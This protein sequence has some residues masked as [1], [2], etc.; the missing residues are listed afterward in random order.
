MINP[1][2][3][4]NI[5]IEMTLQR[6]LL[7]V[8]VLTLIYFAAQTTGGDHG[9]RQF[10]LWAFAASAI[11]W[12]ARLANDSVLEEIRDHTWE[13]QRMSS[14][15]A[16][17]MAWGKLFGATIYAW[18]IAGL[19]LLFY[20][21]GYPTAFSFDQDVKT[22]ILVV[23][24]GVFVHTVAIMSSLEVSR[25]DGKR[26][27]G[28][29]WLFIVVA[30]LSVVS[31]VVGQR[32][33]NTE[34]YG[35]VVWYN[36]EANRLDFLVWSAVVF[37]AWGLLGCYRALRAELLYRTTPLAWLAFL[38]F[39][40][41]YYNGFT[42]AASNAI[43]AWSRQRIA[44]NGF[45]ATIFCSYLIAISSAWLMVLTEN[46]D[47]SRFRKA[48]LRFADSQRRSE[49][50]YLVPKW[51][52]SAAL[53]VILFTSIVVLRSTLGRME[54]DF[55]YSTTLFAAALLLLF[56]RDTL[57][58]LWCHCTTGFKRR[59]NTTAIIYFFILYGIA[60]WLF[61]ASGGSWMLKLFL[62]VPM[63]SPAELVGIGTQVVVMA[64]LLQSRWKQVMSQVA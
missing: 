58:V 4:R 47:L 2:F 30:L 7:P 14:I 33:L 55:R 1:E 62:P 48:L 11:L 34:F 10:F 24:V 40:M 53:T 39:L 52:V 42:W 9:G 38:L 46:K 60:P 12:G 44:V 51:V 50:L 22:I 26:L 25:T 15:G 20:V 29:P 13:N 49:I 17:P 18:Y 21:L 57:I 19:C 6:M 27:R 5:W 32:Q 35:S 54:G 45:Q 43:Q 64:L 37:A 28:L 3:R 41:V 36:I 16:W 63:E 59:A 61:G 23:S 31:T 8:V 56:M